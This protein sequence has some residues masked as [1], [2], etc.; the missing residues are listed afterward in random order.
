MA[1]DHPGS[2]LDLDEP[3][4]A[5]AAAAA[6]TAF[7]PASDRVYIDEYQRVPALLDAVKARLNRDGR[8]GQFVLAGST[9]S[10]SLPA[11]TQ[12]LTGR[13]LRLPV[14]PFAQSEIEGASGPTTVFRLLY[15]DASTPAEFTTAT[16]KEDY[17]RRLAAGGFPSA[18]LA[19]SE[20]AR[21]RW[22]AGYTAQT[23]GRDLP[24]IEPVRRPMALR[25][26]LGIVAART[27]QTL[28]LSNLAA[29]AGL[30]PKTTVIYLDLLEA[31][32]VVHQLQAWAP[33]AT[34]RSF[35]KPK[36][37]I[38]DTGLGAHLL[39]L[40]PE[41]L[42]R[43]TAE[44]LTAFGHLLESFVVAE[45]LKEISW[46]DEPASVGHWRTYEGL[47]VDLVVE[48]W[49]GSILAF[50][51]TAAQRLKQGDLAGLRALRAKTGA[52]FKAGVVLHTGLH[53]SHPEDRL[54]TMPIDR[55]WRLPPG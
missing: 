30:N 53:S 54:F 40:S 18:V 25:R 3:I 48:T 22:F 26:L 33:V 6:P 38:L 9:S 10:N 19:R 17:V 8:P 45:V 44:S 55:L 43:R 31:A 16:D 23:V 34:P 32:F 35:K 46:L 47:E 15:G 39:R 36:T 11:G 20:A 50:E 27:G 13:L 28:N 41:K 24:M 51:V 37:H 29:E 14:Y 1:A 5:D 4:V 49:D 7:L 21:Q 52:A 42:A 2:Y 12:A